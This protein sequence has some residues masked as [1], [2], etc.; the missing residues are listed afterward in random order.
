MSLNKKLFEIM[1][2]LTPTVISTV[3]D[4]KP[5]TTFITWAIAKDENTVRIGVSTNS[6]TVENIRNNENVCFEVF[7]KDTAL[8]VSGKA[9]I[10][11]KSIEG[12]PFPVAII[13][14]EV[15]DIKDNLFPGATI[16]GKIPFVHTGNIEKAEELDNKVLKAL[17][18]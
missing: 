7:D 8:S 5:Y 14:I 15:E 12:I 4:D 9:K 16:E 6:Q 2:D 17:K 1:Q 11:K 10:L 18:E 13:E 3:K